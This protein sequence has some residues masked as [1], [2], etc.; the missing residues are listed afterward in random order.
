[1]GTQ[2]NSPGPDKVFPAEKRQQG[3]DRE[4]VSEL[5][6]IVSRMMVEFPEC[7]RMYSRLAENYREKEQYRLAALIYRMAQALE[8]DNPDLNSRQDENR[9]ERMSG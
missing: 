3:L 4:A 5:V 8:P 1:M 6:Q 2:G 7:S 9:P